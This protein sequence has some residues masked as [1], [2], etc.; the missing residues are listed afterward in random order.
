MSDALFLSLR[1]DTHVERRG[2]ELIIHGAGD[3]TV[4]FRNL[5]RG[6]HEAMLRLTS[7]GETEANLSDIVLS[8]DGAGALAEYYYHLRVLEQK[9]L[10]WRSARA[11]AT[12]LATV[13]PISPCFEFTTKPVTRNLRYQ[14]SRFAFTRALAGEVVLESPL[15]HARVIIADPR[16]AIFV[17]ALARPCAIAETGDPGVGLSEDAVIQLLTLLINSGM[18]TEVEE[19]GAAREEADLSLKSWEFHDLLFHTRSR[20]GRHDQP[21][22]GTYRFAG[23]F[24][25]PS[26]LKVVPSVEKIPLYRPDIERLKQEDLPFAFVQEGRRS[27]RTYGAQPLTKCQLGEFL[28]RVARVTDYR[29]VDAPTPCGPVHT[30]LTHR[31]YPSGGALY[32]LEMYVVVNACQELASG[33]YYY[34]PLNH[35]LNKISGQSTKV[36][37]LLAGAS[38]ATLIPSNDLQVLLIVSARFQRIAWKYASMA[39]AAVLKHVGVLYQTMYLVATAMG[40]APC[41]VG[42]GNADLFSR[43]VGVNYYDESS[44]GEFLLGSSP[45]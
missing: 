32:E 30:D 42:T 36:E 29:E 7:T 34:D 31:P 24:P 38:S 21:V 33:L 37:E 22:G 10:L 35:E 12:L 16:A 4:N 26:A 23:E 43:A 25:P 27:I 28:Y 8:N 20:M 44:V 14:L 2:D 9:C 3:R 5:S 13:T 45:A 40:L 11:D 39:Y 18:V 15:S 6:I 17:H 19:D 1:R 41:G